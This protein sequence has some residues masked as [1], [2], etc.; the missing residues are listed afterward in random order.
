MQS[1]HSAGV[2]L[3][4]PPKRDGKQD[5]NVFPPRGGPEPDREWCFTGFHK[6]DDIVF[7]LVIWIYL[8]FKQRNQIEPEYLMPKLNL[9]SKDKK[10]K[11]IELPL[12]VI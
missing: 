1:E 6:E 10:L 9:D 2:P 5:P 4:V 8:A 7:I 11:I 12:L 3:Q